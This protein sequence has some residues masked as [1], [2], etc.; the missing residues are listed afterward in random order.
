[1]KKQVSLLFLCSV[2][3]FVSAREVPLFETPVEYREVFLY[4]WNPSS[5]ISQERL[6]SDIDQLL[7]IIQVGYAGYDDMVGRGF[8][9]DS[10]RNF[11]LKSFEGQSEIQVVDL[12]GKICESLRHYVRD[13]HFSV[14]HGISQTSLCSESIVYWSD[15]Y[16]Q[17]SE[18]GYFVVQCGSLDFLMGQKY[19][20]SE[21]NLFPYISMGR[22]IYRLAR[23]SDTK[24]SHFQFEFQKKTVSVPLRDAGTT[25][26]TNPLKF[27][28]LET[29]DS[30]YVSMNGFSLPQAENS[31]R[32][33]AEFIFEKYARAGEKYRQKKNII[34][35]LRGNQGGNEVYSANF[36]YMLHSSEEFKNFKKLMEKMSRWECES[37]INRKCFISPVSVQAEHL[38]SV[39][40]HPGRSEREARE[41][42][43]MKK[44][45]RRKVVLV[46]PEPSATFTKPSA[47][48][49]K[50]VIL[51]DRNTASA[52][53][54]TVIMAKEIFGEQNVLVAGENSFGMA[55]FWHIVSLRLANSGI[56]ISSAFHKNLKIERIPQWQGEGL[57]YFP[58]FWAADEDLNETVFCITGDKNMKEMLSAIELRVNDSEI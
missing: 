18:A 19:T 2:M 17:K 16:V 48:Q 7:Y 55:Q 36:F 21:K 15:I 44:R 45:P 32:K 41:V 43:R 50:I 27:S 9:S 58:D 24:I 57:G 30:A 11:I 28:E 23:I 10:C 34:L 31:A 38:Y 52:G 3:S 22:D 37:N 40:R 51:I 5:C 42:L 35:D 6:R 54:G 39:S 13:S 49:G 4:D 8:S 56:G 20:G 26:I 33:E 53:E 25:S 14:L 47:F 46:E 29:E 12:Y 1:M